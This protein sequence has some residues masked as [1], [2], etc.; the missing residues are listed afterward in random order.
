MKSNEYEEIQGNACLVALGVQG[1]T[2]GRGGQSPDGDVATAG[3]PLKKHEVWGGRPEPAFTQVYIYIR[4]I[5]IKMCKNL[6]YGPQTYAQGY[7]ASA[8]AR[9]KDEHVGVDHLDK[10][11]YYGIYI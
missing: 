7:G 5:K 4:K 8:R 3:L 10:G 9:A 2:R 1:Q 6:R 11:V